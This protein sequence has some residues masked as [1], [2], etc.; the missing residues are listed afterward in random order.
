MIPLS[1]TGPTT[2]FPFWVIAIIAINVYVFY[3]ELTSPS[4]DTFITQYALIPSA[5]NLLSPLSLIPFVTS[6]FLHGG[7]IHI[8]S[9]M[10]FLWIFGDNVEHKLGPLFFPIFYLFSGLAGNI[11]QYL[12]IAGSDI[13]LLGASGAIA[14][15]LGAYYALFPNNKVK[16]L[17]FILLF[18]TILEIPA[19]FILFYWLVLQLFNSAASIA[20]ST[21]SMDIGGVAYF[22]HIGGF[23]LGW[24]FGKL[25]NITSLQFKS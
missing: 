24:F 20:P 18:V 4:I 9:N 17:V 5:V 13:P 3:L 19:S 14:G 25:L 21:S 16:T 1:D 10:W 6:Q 15:V 11:L 2:R 7:F 8:I 12:F 23:T 22:A